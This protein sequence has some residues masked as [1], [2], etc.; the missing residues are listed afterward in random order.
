[1][2]HEGKVHDNY[3]DSGEPWSIRFIYTIVFNYTKPTKKV[4]IR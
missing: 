4:L 1:M 3:A 2:K